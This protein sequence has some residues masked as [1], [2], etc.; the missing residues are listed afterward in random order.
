MPLEGAVPPNQPF[1]AIVEQGRAIFDKTKVLLTDP[2]AGEGIRGEPS[3][4]LLTNPDNAIAAFGERASFVNTAGEVIRSYMR[5][6]IDEAELD[7]M[8]KSASAHKFSDSHNQTDGLANV[9]LS[10]S[11]ALET[12]IAANQLA[13]EK[14]A[15]TGR[16]W[17]GNPL[18]IPPKPN[19]KRMSGELSRLERISE[20]KNTL[21]AGVNKLDNKDDLMKQ[22]AQEE[23]I[24]ARIALGKEAVRNGTISDKS[25]DYA[26]VTNAS[27]SL[28]EQSEKITKAALSR[29]KPGEVSPSALKDALSTYE[30]WFNTL[31]ERGIFVDWAGFNFRQHNFLEPMAQFMKGV[32]GTSDTIVRRFTHVMPSPAITPVAQ[33]A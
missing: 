5:G 11:F 18:G 6:G 33:T 13:N 22:V 12:S 23:R 3:R 26:E 4:E 8:I 17:L 32:D 31:R 16:R 1:E 24:V 29:A 28:T 15:H 27:F 10:R 7:G 9:L 30:G 20:R 2:F 14:K 25:E 21:E 19:I